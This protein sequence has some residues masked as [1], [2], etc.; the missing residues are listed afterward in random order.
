V[1]LGQKTRNEAIE[2]LNDDL[3]VPRIK[4]IMAKIGYVEPAAAEDGMARLVAY[5][6][7][8]K[9]L[10]VAALRAHLAE[11]LLES[12]MPTHFV[13]LDRMPLTTNGKIDRA[14]LPEPT[15]ENIQSAEDF[16]A[17]VTA[18]EKKLAALWCDLLKIDSIGRNDNFFGLGGHSLLVMRAVSR[19]R[20]SFGVDVQLRNLF[21][22]PTVAGLAEVIDGMVW[23][24]ESM[25]SRI[26]EGPREEIEL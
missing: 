17:P 4:E 8:S 19:M 23:A 7:S 12:M 25:A 24:V 1:R 14:A 6:V 9:Q 21:E 5:Y 26:S 10:T 2:E 16:V 3:D 13:R 11:D 22:R 15:A 20:E 18:T